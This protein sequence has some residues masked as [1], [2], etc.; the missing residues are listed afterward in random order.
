MEQFEKIIC[1]VIKRSRIY[2]FEVDE[3]EV[4]FTLKKD[5]LR[6]IENIKVLS[7]MMSDK[8]HQFADRN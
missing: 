4:E 1:P 6:T 7:V 3:E 2:P 8:L 5:E